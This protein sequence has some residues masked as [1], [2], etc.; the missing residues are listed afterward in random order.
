[1]FLSSGAQKAWHIVVTIIHAPG[2]RHYILIIYSTSH[3]FYE[4]CSSATPGWFLACSSLLSIWRYSNRYLFFA[5]FSPNPYMTCSM[6]AIIYIPYKS[7]PKVTSDP[8]WAHCRQEV[9]DVTVAMARLTATYV[10]TGVFRRHLQT[11][12]TWRTRSAFRQWWWMKAWIAFTHC[13]LTTLLVLNVQKSRKLL[14]QMGCQCIT[15]LWSQ[16]SKLHLHLLLA[17]MSVGILND[18]HY[19][20]TYASNAI[21]ITF[22]SN[23]FPFVN[24]YNLLISTVWVSEVWSEICSRISLSFSCTVF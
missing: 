21:I 23:Y 11:Y 10:S 14:H 15:G 17:W 24:Y 4:L 3:I 13:R 12:I 16:R 20:I 2:K 8:W 18:F 7:L 22:V 1:M 5:S 6:P 9:M 19:R